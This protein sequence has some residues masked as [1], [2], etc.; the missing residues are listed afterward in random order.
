[1]TLPMRKELT[2]SELDTISTRLL[3]FNPLEEKGFKIFGE[4][5][6]PHQPSGNPKRGFWGVRRNCSYSVVPGML[7]GTDST[8]VLDAHEDD[9]H[10][11]GSELRETSIESIAKILGVDLQSEEVVET[12]LDHSSDGNVDIMVSPIWSVTVQVTWSS[13]EYSPCSLILVSYFVLLRGHRIQK[14]Q[15]VAT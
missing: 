10:R 7:P 4:A 14:A 3:K 6:F 9:L 12:A 2:E 15:Q 13:S 1:M 11:L 5:S 8:S